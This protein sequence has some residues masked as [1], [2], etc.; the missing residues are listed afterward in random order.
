MQAH[1]STSISKKRPAALRDQLYRFY[2][3]VKA[4]KVRSDQAVAE[5]RRITGWP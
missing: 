4:A 1:I 5:G 2:L 3:A